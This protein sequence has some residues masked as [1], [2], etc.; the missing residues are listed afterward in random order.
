M[1]QRNQFLSD[2]CLWVEEFI[3]RKN[4]KAFLQSM[5]KEVNRA[6][7]HQRQNGLKSLLILTKS[8]VTPKV[9]SSLR[10]SL[11]KIA[12]AANCDFEREMATIRL[13]EVSENILKQQL[14]IANRITLKKYFKK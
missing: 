8:A 14:S 6:R 7:N 11:N 3:V 10:F 2:F 9:N 5:K 13:V 12:V 1:L 4:A